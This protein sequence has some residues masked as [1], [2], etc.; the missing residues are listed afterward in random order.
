MFHDLRALIYDTAARTRAKSNSGERQRKASTA[1]LQAAIPSTMPSTPHVV[2]LAVHLSINTFKFNA[3]PQLQKHTRA[4]ERR[5][6]RDCRTGTALGLVT[7]NECENIC[8]HWLN[9]L[10]NWKLRD[11][12]FVYPL[13]F[14]K[15]FLKALLGLGF[16]PL[17]PTIYRP[18]FSSDGSIWSQPSYQYAT[19]CASLAKM[20]FLTAF[21]HPSDSTHRSRIA[22]AVPLHKKARWLTWL[23]HAM[24]NQFHCQHLASCTKV[25]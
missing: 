22:A 15:R 9:F 25:Q 10:A 5:A 3:A 7:N 8:H 20:T 19:A 2:T 24:W 14:L 13:I 6:Q 21:A 16:D 17:S 11:P 4:R 18:S 1:W 23:S 12:S